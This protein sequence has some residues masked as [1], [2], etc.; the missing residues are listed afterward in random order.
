MTFSFDTTLW[1]SGCQK[2]VFDTVLPKK[3]V[4]TSVPQKNILNSGPEMFFLYSGSQNKSFDT[5]VSKNS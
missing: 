2:N 4:D 5:V 1:Y 3:S